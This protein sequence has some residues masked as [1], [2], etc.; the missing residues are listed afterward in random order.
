MAGLTILYLYYNQPEAVKFLEK[1]GL[2]DYDV[3]FLFVDDASKIPLEVDWSD[4]IRILI[5]VEWNQPYAN[6]MALK[7]LKNGI[8]LRMDIDHYFKKE[9]II[10]LKLLAKFIKENEI[11]HFKRGNKT[12]HKNIYMARVEDL[13]KAGGYDER[14]CGN[15]GYDD[16][17]FMRRLKRKKWT[18]T[19]SDIEVKINHNGG[20]KGLNRDTTINKALYEKSNS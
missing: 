13:L 12:P 14:F 1:Q 2:P 17:E 8:V 18:F 6:N 9:D 10:Y 4:V 3:D 16:S 20:T 15:Y 19:K 5:D 7:Q 11:I